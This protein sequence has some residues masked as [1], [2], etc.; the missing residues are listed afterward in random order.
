MNWKKR[1]IVLAIGFASAG[2][3][4]A[5]ADL[6]MLGNIERHQAEMGARNTGKSCEERFRSYE[7]RQMSPARRRHE[8]AEC[9][10]LAAEAAE[11][12]A[13]ADRVAT[14]AGSADVLKP[15]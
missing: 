4:A 2:A 11:A 10:R 12:Q 5:H 14:T 15:R 6:G 7:S 9:L 1:V 3:P 8:R 13:V